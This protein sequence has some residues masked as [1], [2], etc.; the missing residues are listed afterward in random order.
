MAQADKEITSKLRKGMSKH[1][2]LAKNDL[3][4]TMCQYAVQV[5][6]AEMKKE[7]TEQAMINSLAGACKLAPE[8]TYQECTELV[9]TYGVYLIELLIQFVDPLKV[10]EVIKLC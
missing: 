3:Y 1:K 4:C 6:D 7:S 2:M 8:S 10:C 9:S 5:L